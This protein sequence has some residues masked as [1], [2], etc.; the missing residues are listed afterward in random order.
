M[1]S[2]AIAF[3]KA[4]LDQ[5]ARQAFDLSRESFVSPY[6]SVFG[7]SNLFGV[8]CYTTIQSCCR[9]HSHFHFQTGST[10]LAR[11]AELSYPVPNELRPPELSLL[12][13]SSTVNTLANKNPRVAH[14]ARFSSLIVNAHVRRSSPSIQ[15]D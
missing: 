13:I 1:Q 12:T 7:K 4:T 14:V 8:C 5:S 9:C 10:Y 15:S 6:F 2:D 11:H 3:P